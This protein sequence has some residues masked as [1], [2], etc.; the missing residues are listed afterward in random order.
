MRGKLL[1]WINCYLANRWQTVVI[2]GS[3]SSPQKVISGVPQGTV[4]GPI[5]FIIYLNDLE[6]CIKHSVIS[7]F[8]DDTRLKRA[9]N[10]TEDTVLL[11]SDLNNS[12]RWSDENNM[13]L[14]QSKFEL[15]THTTGQHNYLLDLPFSAEYTEYHTA[16]GSV[17][18]PQCTVKDLGITISSDASWSPHIANITEDAKK[19]ASW[20]LSVF[21]DRSA[22]TLLPL[23]KTLVRSRVE[24]CGPL[25]NPAKIEDIQRLESIQRSF[26]ARITEVKHLHYWDRLKTLNLMS[27]QRRRERYCVIQVFKILHS[28]SPND[29]GL[30]F[31][32]TKR[33]GLCCKVP[34][35]VKGSKQKI[36]KIYEDSFRVTGAK[37]WNQVPNLIRQK[38]S[39]DSF[40]AALTKY[41]LLLQDHPPVPG[42]SSSNSLRTILASGGSAL[43]AVEDDGGWEVCNLLAGS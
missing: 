12:I 35:L 43:G 14:H 2:Q 37:L 22:E 26:T 13:Q 33:R 9:I 8:A 42:I 30:E 32:Q 10:T 25:W 38:T 1:S 23:Y 5:L 16:D 17:I 3:H 18:S 28:L 41:L 36:Q 39:L 19:M 11:Q 40:K 24:Y 7:S 29:I 4:L 20:I 21:H 27:L 34:P 15:I 31:I 6:S